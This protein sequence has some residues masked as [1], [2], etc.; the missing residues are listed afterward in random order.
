MFVLAPRGQPIGVT[1]EGVFLTF[2][3]YAKGELGSFGVACNVLTDFSTYIFHANILHSIIQLIDYHGNFSD[4]YIISAGT[5]V[6][7]LYP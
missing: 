7:M 2:Q 6:H 4:T 5:C 1:C 3:S